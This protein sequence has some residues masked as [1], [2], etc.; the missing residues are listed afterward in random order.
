VVDMARPLVHRM[1]HQQD[2]PGFRGGSEWAC[3]FC[4]YRVVYRRLHH[5]V[6]VTGQAEVLH[7]RAMTEVPVHLDDLVLELT[8]ADHNW[9]TVNAITW[10]GSVAR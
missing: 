4:L 10:S 5:K 2:R 7:V 6:M 3:P 8:E 9:L 1:V